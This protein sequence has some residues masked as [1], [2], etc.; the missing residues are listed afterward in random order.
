MKETSVSEKKIRIKTISSFIIF[1]LLLGAG[2]SA[3]I[4]VRK[5]PPAQGTLSGIPAPIRKVL[6]SNEKLFSNTFSDR[7]AKTYSTSEAAKKVRV[8]GSVGMKGEFDAEAWKLQLLKSNGD[9]VSFSL[10]EIKKLPKTE[11]VYDFKCIEG[12]SQKTWWGGVKFIDFINHFQLQKEAN[13]NY[14]A[15]NTPDKKYY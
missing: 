7:L 11:I 10:D 5:Q 8:N 4:W 3:W 6:N 2:A 13:F 12:W 9:T 14:V 1:F 15:L